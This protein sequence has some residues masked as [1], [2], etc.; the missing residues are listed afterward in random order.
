MTLK[1]LNGTPPQEFLYAAPL[2]QGQ[3]LNIFNVEV[4]VENLGGSWRDNSFILV[5]RSTH[6][7]FSVHL[8]GLLDGVE[9][10]IR[11]YC[12]ASECSD[13]TEQLPKASAVSSILTFTVISEQIETFSSVLSLTDEDKENRTAFCKWLEDV[14]KLYV[15]DHKLYQFGSS[16]NGMG[17][18]GC[19]L[20]V[21]LLTNFSEEEHVTLDNFPT[22]VDVETGRVSRETIARLSPLYMTKFLKSVLDNHP[23]ITDVVRINGRCPILKFYNS[24]HDIFCDLSFK[25]Q[26][27]L[28]NTALIIFLGKLDERFLVIARIV[29]YWAKHCGLV[30]GVDK[31]SSYAL[32]LLV[33]HFFQAR[34]PPILPPVNEIAFKSEYVQNGSI[35]DTHLLSEDLKKFSPSN[36][37]KS[38]EELLR[39]FFFYYLNFDFKQVI[40]PATGCSVPVSSFMAQEDFD[41]TFEFNTV[42]V[43]DPFRLDSNITV[44]TQFPVCKKFRFCLQL[45]CEA[46]QSEFFSTP[47]SEKFGLSSIFLKPSFISKRLAELQA[48]TLHTIE[49][50]SIPNAASK[51]KEILEYGLLFHCI[52]FNTNSNNSSDSNTLLKLRCRTYIHIWHG[53]DLV[54]EKIR[55]K[56][57][58]SPLERE[59]LISKEI[60]AKS[61]AK[62]KELLCEFD[63]ECKESVKDN[64][65]KL[66]VHLNFKKA[67]PLSVFLKEFI[68]CTL[69]ML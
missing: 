45:T 28:Q 42:S 3:E 67:S 69:R 25:N 15:S 44:A 22:P 66:T 64:E 16:V 38:A 8:G 46:F 10:F 41:R 58:L 53:R 23:D 27:S 51:V 62:K 32:S 40:V 17:F 50:P 14:F 13:K 56:D 19:D 48:N 63:C 26:F 12:V 47:G 1:K 61:D 18:K 33:L 39:E 7:K 24:K 57:N 34:V 68:P 52:S 49:V 59:H 36:N 5:G 37:S 2:L 35:E 6:S 11:C 65:T 54:S 60:A 30:D 31:F 20:D 29:R 55:V 43:Q 9:R 4:W 21:C